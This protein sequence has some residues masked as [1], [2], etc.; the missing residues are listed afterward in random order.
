M[1]N[2]LVFKEAEPKE[3]TPVASTSVAVEAPKPTLAP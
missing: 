3:A 2:K 1:S